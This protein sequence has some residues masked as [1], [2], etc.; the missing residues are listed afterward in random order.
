M[1]S[2]PVVP[3][4]L[5]LREGI[6]IIESAF[7]SGRLCGLDVVEICPNVGSDVDVKRTIDSA[8][9]LVKAAC[10]SQRSGNAPLTQRDIPKL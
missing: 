7:D 2:L 5:T 3:G 6:T 9:E 4:G 10:G 1:F 8:I